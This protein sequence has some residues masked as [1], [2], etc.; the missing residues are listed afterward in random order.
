MDIEK[1]TL[2]QNDK[3]QTNMYPYFT[4]SAKV[5][6]SVVILHGMAEHHERYKG[7]AGFLAANGY[8]VFL[9]DHRGHGK[10]KKYEELGHFADNN[11]Y[12]LVIS[13]AVSVVNYV[14]NN[15]R[16]QKLIL[17]GH[18]MGS[19]IARCVLAEYDKFDAVILLGTTHQRALKT[20]LGCF[21]A[22]CIKVLK[23]PTH[24]SPFL[25]NSTT[26]YKSFSRISNRT[27][28]DWLTRDNSLVGL[29]INDPYCG[30]MC[31]TSFY[32]DLIKLTQIASSNRTIKKVRRDLPILIM[33]GLDDPVGDY[34]KG[35]SRFYATLQRYGFTASHCVIYDECRHELLNELNKDE[36]MADIL[37][38]T[39]EITVPQATSSSEA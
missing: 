3:Y 19:L 2:T 1:I 39:D 36:V 4:N 5:K 18:S 14:Q 22:S 27:K 13:D 6:G 15:N 28:F 32:Y 31:T 35:V 16:G 29:Y 23:S 21:L 8:D 34:G 17:L 33:S 38:W 9:Y 12:K 10:D 7:F 30:Y 20:A 11:G 24:R 26:G 37:K 25:A